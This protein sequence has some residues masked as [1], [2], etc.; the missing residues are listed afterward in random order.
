VEE[1]ISLSNVIKSAQYVSLDDIKLLQAQ[2]IMIKTPSVEHEPELDK[3]RNRE[4][5]L[6]TVKNQLMQEA[7]A[8]ASEQIR[9]A[10][11]EVQ[12]LRQTAQAEINDW[13][14]EQREQDTIHVTAAQDAGFQEGF[15]EGLVTAQEQVQQQ[16]H[17]MLQEASTILEQAHMLKQ[18][19]INEA[20]PF[21]IE[22]STAIAAK[23]IDKQLTS[24][25]DWV[26]EM[27]KS[28]LSRRREQGIITICVSPANFS[29]VQGFREELVL[30]MDSQAE[31]QILPDASIT[32]HGCVLRSSFG[33]I[34]A[35]VDTQL[36]EIKKALLHIA[37]G[38]GESTNHGDT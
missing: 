36:A 2:E 5:E 24:H 9:Q 16:Y 22:L 11:E 23:I 30:I 21:L 4:A 10:D 34:D 3:L 38:S 35:R 8:Y 29:Y 14:L 18:Q 19:I 17:E 20:E 31:L 6:L 12:L 27:V 26:I 32:D 1:T 13:W 33:S 15:Q 25:N 7:E 28:V 37:K